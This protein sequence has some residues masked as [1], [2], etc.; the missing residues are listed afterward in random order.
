MLAWKLSHKTFA[1]IAVPLIFELVFIFVLNDL[2]QKAEDAAKKESVAR[3]V[4]AETN[5]LSQMLYETIITMV[6]LGIS[7]NPILE[8]R[9]EKNLSKI[10][11]EL[12]LLRRIA[13][14]TNQQRLCVDAVET[15]AIKGLSMVADVRR[16]QKESP[17]GALAGGRRLRNDLQG[18]MHAILSN[19]EEIAVEERKILP[20]PEAEAKIRLSAQHSMIVGVA[21]NIV[22]AI[23]LAWIFTRGTL[24]RL[25]VLMDNTRRL[26]RHENLHMPLQGGDEIA[27][28][29]RVFHE[30]VRDMSESRKK[31]SA[32]IDYAN[33]VICSLSNDSGDWVF[34]RVSPASVQ[35]WNYLPEL[36]QGRDLSSLVVPEDL[37]NTFQFFNSVKEGSEESQLENRIRTRKGQVVH[38]LWSM[39]WSTK[40]KLMFCVAHDITERKEIERLKQEFVGIVSHDL[41]SPLTSLLFSLNLLSAGAR[42]ELPQAAKKDITSA[43][44]SIRRLIA[45]IN[46]LLDIEKMEAGKMQMQFDDTDVA[47]VLGRSCEA[48]EMLAAQ[49]NIALRVVSN[50]LIITAD[51]DRLI[52]VLVNF[53]SNAVKY[54]PNNDEILV[55]AT[56]TA[57][58][59]EVRVTDHGPGIPVEYKDKVFDRFQQVDEPEYQKQ[60]GTGL[61]LA[62][63]KFIII[64]HGGTIGV[65]SQA[66][67][68]SSFWFKIPKR[69]EA[70]E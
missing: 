56:T 17:T 3:A 4:I 43:E 64:G 25:G 31:E 29:D 21:I 10:P 61:G 33:D 47:D 5:T 14:H 12:N 11:A 44:S 1:L 13:N 7:P 20:D 45:L 52:Q 62:I 34:T 49:R 58:M 53:L 23:I 37:T 59:V 60:G 67:S 66:G 50:N 40:E 15:A 18:I 69:Q 39:Y 30:M 19:L 8:E 24:Q 35:N 51:G 54:S 2:L 57:D 65:D 22:L 63:S 32:I 70:D 55:Q 36:L 27:H 38:V 6:A 9:F 26:A 16:Q 48:V 46:D 42:G 28:L 68:G 41:R